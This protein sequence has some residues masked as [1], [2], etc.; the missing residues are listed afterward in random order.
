MQLSYSEPDLP[1]PQSRKKL[2]RRRSFR[3]DDGPPDI[4]NSAF[5]KQINSSVY[6]S[7]ALVTAYIVLRVNYYIETL[8]EQLLF[9]ARMQ[10]PGD[11][12][13]ARWAV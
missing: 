3:F 7:M 9:T 8:Y 5:S 11:I 13:A 12:D 6:W 1:R 4:Y 10:Y 2:F